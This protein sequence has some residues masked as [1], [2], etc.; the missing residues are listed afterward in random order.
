MFWSIS[1]LLNL[2]RFVFIAKGLFWCMFCGYLK[3]TCI[4]LSLGGMFYK[5]QSDP[6]ISCCCWVVPY[7]YWFFCP[8]GL[9]LAE[10]RV[11]KSSPRVGGFWI[12]LC[13]LPDLSVLL[14]IFSNSSVCC[15]LI[16][17]CYVFWVDWQFCHSMMSSL[18]LAV[19][20]VL[21][22]TSILI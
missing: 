11:M 9:S 22:V 14:H 16:Y 15:T 10:W 7:S 13:L 5:Y 8:V 3:R 18:S 12:C 20:L 21:K 6:T 4:L 1:V 2:L 19:V 17:N